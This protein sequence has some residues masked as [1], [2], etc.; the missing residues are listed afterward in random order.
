[1]KAAMETSGA[2]SGVV[3]PKPRSLVYEAFQRKYD[4]DENSPRWKKLF[5]RYVFLPFNRFCFFRLQLISPDHTRNGE[6]GWLERQGVFSEQWRAEQ[7]AAKYRFGGVEPLAFDTGEDDCT[8]S[9]RS[10]FPNS[11]AR[12]KY[13]K[14]SQQV[15]RVE[16][17]AMQRLKNTL[18][19]SDRG[20]T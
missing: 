5:F 10:L 3:P 1:M 11:S 2:G 9:P 17:G 19:L 8:C 12:R 15:V 16:V 18:A 6:L 14:K 4:I 20:E 7:E 13:E